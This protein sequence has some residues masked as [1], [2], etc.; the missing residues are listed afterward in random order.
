MPLPPEIIPSLCGFLD[1]FGCPPPSAA[2][3]TLK[4]PSMMTCTSGWPKT[5]FP[6]QRAEPP[7]EAVLENLQIPPNRA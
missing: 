7:Q 3:T 2:A 1:L 5:S 6:G 4:L